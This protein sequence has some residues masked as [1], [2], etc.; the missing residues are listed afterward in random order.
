MKKI[1]VVG[2]VNIDTFIHVEKLEY[3]R[4]HLSKRVYTDV[5]GKGANT[6]AALAKLGFEPVLLAS[7]GS[8]S[9]GKSAL[10]R[11]EKL[12]VDT[13]LVNFSSFHTGRTFVVVDNQGQNTMFH[14]LGANKDLLAENVN[15]IFLEN[16]SIVFVQFGIPI[17]TAREVVVMAKRNGKTVFVDPGGL[18]SEVPFD[19]LPFIDIIAPNESE[20]F[21]L[22]GKDTVEKGAKSLV[23]RGIE[24]VLVKQDKKGASL[25]TAKSSFHFNAYDVNVVDTT[26]AGDAFNGAFIAAMILK[27]DPYDALKLAVASASLAVQKKGT[28]SSSPVREELMGFLKERGEDALLKSLIM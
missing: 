14:A 6:A 20:L 8:D 18:E 12:G 1:A 16:S 27:M 25:Y 7:V 10:K 11:L 9:S 2:K 28:S 15:W 23:S 22:S 4:N 19:I 3:G 17:E 21:A 13:S 26:G 24:T 5:G